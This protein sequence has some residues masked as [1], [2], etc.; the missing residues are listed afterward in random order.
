MHTLPSGWFRQVNVK[1]MYLFQLNPKCRVERLLSGYLRGCVIISIVNGR[2]GSF[3]GCV[4]I[5]F[6]LNSLHQLHI[7][8]VLEYWKLRA[9]S[10]SWNPYKPMRDYKFIQKYHRGLNR[11]PAR[12]YICAC[13]NQLSYRCHN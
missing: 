12:T 9:I 3:G 1:M 6:N 5:S 2:S 11:V 8:A 13:L 7:N 4:I 10:Y